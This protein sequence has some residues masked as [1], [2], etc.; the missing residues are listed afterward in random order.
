V[1][2]PVLGT[3]VKPVLCVFWPVFPLEAATNV[4]YCAV[5]VVVSLV[6]AVLVAL[7]AVVAVAALPVHEAEEPVV[8]WFSVGMSAATI[9]LNVGAPATPFGAAKTV[10][11]V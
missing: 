8:F 4:M 5:A 10:L 7:V 9:A 2:E 1:K 3:K 11:A 6:I